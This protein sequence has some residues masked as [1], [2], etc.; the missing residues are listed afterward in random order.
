SEPLRPG[1]ADPVRTD[2]DHR[3]AVADRIGLPAAADRGIGAGPVPAAAQPSPSS[4]CARR[5]PLWRGDPPYG[6]AHGNGP[7]GS[8]RRAPR[9]SRRRRL[10]RCGGVAHR[11]GDR[12]QLHGADGWSRRGDA[13]M[14]ASPMIE[15]RGLTRVFGDFTAVDAIS[16]DVHA[17]EVF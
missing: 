9:V 16:F 4:A 1:R 2:P 15:A 6:L 5:L 3:Y 7:A 10:P 14:S 11:G 17:G 12:G 13:V 8:G